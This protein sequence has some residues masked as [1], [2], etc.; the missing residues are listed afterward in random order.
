MEQLEIRVRSWKELPEA[1]NGEMKGWDVKTPPLLPSP[2][3]QCLGACDG[4][5]L[6]NVLFPGTMTGGQ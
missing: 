3:A 1:G 5:G 6:L 2:R 4:L